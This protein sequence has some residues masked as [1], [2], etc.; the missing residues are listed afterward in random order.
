[1]EVEVINIGNRIMNNYILKCENGCIVIDTGYEGGFE[2]FSMRLSSNGLSPSDISF[3]FLTHAHDDH[4]G[5]LG[6][7]LDKT[8]APLI[9]HSKAVERLMEGHNRFT[10]GCSSRLAQL[11]LKI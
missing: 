5:F 8:E 6:E 2:R 1:M 9:L 4:A 11:L 3:I 10:G 7:L